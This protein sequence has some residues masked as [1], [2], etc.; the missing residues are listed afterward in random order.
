MPPRNNQTDDAEASDSPST[1]ISVPVKPGLPTTGDAVWLTPDEKCLIQH[2][3][4]HQAEAGDNGNFKPKTFHSAA[5]EVE[6]IRTEGG[7]KTYK[8]CQQKYG[9]VRHLQC[10][11]I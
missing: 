9:T 7:P 8:S 1:G 3:I 11:Q 10:S 2:L 6:K 4:D 5:K